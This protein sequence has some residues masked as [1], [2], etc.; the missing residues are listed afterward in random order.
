MSSPRFFPSQDERK[1]SKIEHIR[2][3]EKKKKKTNSRSL[4]MYKSS[5]LQI[6]LNLEGHIYCI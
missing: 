3:G 5:G 1:N 6:L 2:K 4:I